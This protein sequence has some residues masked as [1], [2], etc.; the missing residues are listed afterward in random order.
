VLYFIGTDSP[1]I[2]AP[3]LLLNPGDSSSFL[4]M[5]NFIS[6]SNLWAKLGQNTGLAGQ[7][8]NKHCF[9]NNKNLFNQ[10]NATRF[11]TNLGSIN[12]P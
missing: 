6:K 10:N 4:P 3:P 12:N 7:K 11:L 9:Q 1:A 8:R 2:D 5:Q